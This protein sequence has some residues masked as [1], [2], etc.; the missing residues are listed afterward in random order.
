[1]TGIFLTS[2]IDVSLFLFFLM[3][4]SSIF[5][6]LSKL[7]FLSNNPNF[8]RIVSKSAFFYGVNVEFDLAIDPSSMFLFIKWYTDCEFIG[9]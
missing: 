9:N 6:Y 4:D 7:P 2:F 3:R 5:C 1:M 8:L